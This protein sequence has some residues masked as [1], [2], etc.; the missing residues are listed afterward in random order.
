MITKAGTFTNDRCP[1]E[2]Y[3]LSTD[4]KPMDA[5]N[6]SLFYEMDT[7]KLYLFDEQNKRWLEQ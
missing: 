6:A 1:S 4:T 3:G 5:R 7:G 2:Y